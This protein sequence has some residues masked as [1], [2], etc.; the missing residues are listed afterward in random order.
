[1][2]IA[3]CAAAPNASMQRR[4]W[5]QREG[6]RSN[7]VDFLPCAYEGVTHDREDG[8]GYKQPR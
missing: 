8:C 3:P 2:S 7:R 1:M 5:N 4:P 6:G